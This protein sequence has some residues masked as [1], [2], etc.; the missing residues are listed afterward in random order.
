MKQKLM[1]VVL[2]AAMMVV[3]GASLA[4]AKVSGTCDNCHTMHNSQDGSAVV[5]TGPN[6]ALTKGGC[7]GCHTGTNDGSNVIPYVMSSGAPTYGT[8][9]LA[10]GNF[11][12]VAG[13]TGTDSMGHNVATD[14]LADPDALA[15]DAS[16]MP[17]GFDTTI[18]GNAGVG[19]G[20]WTATQLTCAGTYGCHGSRAVVTTDD[21][22]AMSGAHHGA[23]DAGAYRDG[24]TLADSYRFLNTIKGVE[25]ADRE[26]TVAADDHNQYHGDDR[27]SA[28]IASD[29]PAD[30]T[31]ISALCAQC[32]GDFHS[33]AGGIAYNN[34]VGNSWLRHPTDIDMNEPGIGA[35]YAAYG[36]AGTNAY[37]PEAPV[38]KVV[39]DDTV[40]ATVL[41]GAASD[42]AIV[43]CISC[44]RAHGSP[45]AD[46]MR[47]NYPT[48][49][50]AAS[51]ASTTGC[52][53]CHTTKDDA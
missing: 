50:N 29:T 20:S 48:V 15:L 8:N 41:G 6:R 3:S 38:A 52:F 13:A 7:V 14:S 23:N 26:Y 4:I 11:Y 32:H 36:G 22:V 47:W 33:N 28:E 19:T 25:D 37:V 51:G 27:T 24:A 49:N 18:A 9:T 45:Y 17:P 16:N 34:N 46:L 40:L 30:T 42:D 10:G 35:E 39:S 1:L 5:A 43:T 31:T 44:H 2:V 12:W 53:Q 21:F